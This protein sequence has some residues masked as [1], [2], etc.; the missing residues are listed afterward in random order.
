M[1]KRQFQLTD[2]EIKVFRQRERQTRDVHELKRLQAVRLYGTGMAINDILAIVDTSESS[3]RQWA[4]HL[5]ETGFEALRSKW[6]GNN[7]KKLND[8]QRSDLRD[9]LHQGGPCAWQ[10]SQGQFWTVSDLEVAVQ[11]WYGVSYQSQRSY[12]G[13]MHECGFSYQRTEKVYRSRA[14]ERDI[15][16]FEADLEKN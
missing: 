12:V 1:A 14:N 13:L 5:R 16:D 10:I 7:A 4:Q 6:Q 11:Q 3:I 9:R 2:E 15:A 8:V